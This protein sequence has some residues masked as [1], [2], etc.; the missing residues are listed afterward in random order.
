M[1]EVED[2][3]G[4]RTRFVVQGNRSMSWRANLWLAASLGAI[5]M[6]IAVALATFGLWLVIPF[7]GAEIVLI[8]TCLYLT[9]RRLSRKE[10]ITVE[11][12]AVRLEWGYTRPD[13]VV[14]LPRQ[15]T[16]AALSQPREPLPHGGPERRGPRP[17]LRARVL[18]EQGR[19]EDAARRPRRG[20]AAPRRRP[21]DARGPNI[22]LWSDDRMTSKSSAWR[23]MP[24]SAL[25][26]VLVA[27]LLA[28]LSG[29]AL[30]D[31]GALNMPDGVTPI[32]E[33]VKGL[34]MLIF[35]ICC[36][37]GVV[38]FGVMIVSMF[39][40][41]KSR[42]AKASDF[43][44]STTVEIVWT[45]VPLVILIAMAIPAARVLI[46]MEDFSDSEMSIKVT[47]YQWRWQYEYLDEGI[48]FYS[49]LDAEQNAARQQGSDIDL[50]Q[51]GETYLRDV[52]N[53]LVVP[54]GR[55]IRFLHTAAD[56]IHSWWVP[57]FAIKKDAIPG[58]INENW[59]TIE[60][61]GI[62]RGK[63]AELCG[64]DHG[65]MPIVVRAVPQEEFDAWVEEKKTELAAADADVMREHSTDELVAL[66]ETIHGRSCVGCHQKEGQGIPGMFPAIAGSEIAT[67]ALD[68]HLATVMDGV[69]G[70]PMAAFRDQ[71]SDTEIAAVVTYQ[72]N[73]FGNATGDA[74]QP[75]AVRAVREG[76]AVEPVRQSLLSIP[77]LNIDAKPATWGVN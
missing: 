22:E 19:E 72:R 64:R 9:L 41:R 67:G 52:D 36:A 55:K 37:I 71:L 54:V 5:C 69:E 76:E 10:V 11:G 12:E 68:A 56:V 65:F 73:A 28:G 2:S 77:E 58:F 18:P 49:A 70:S 45:V 8:T 1:I 40:H 75:R 13:R 38:V 14:D 4:G 35:Y 34:H 53:E 31:W 33:E 3:S 30:A 27:A 32:S 50:E 23:A 66:G 74:L 59:A 6:G 44:E 62:Y 48:A 17:Q 47:G 20:A 42:G 61:P 25:L 46:K 26:S 21:R 15:W 7:A 39:L 57:D 16:P 51:F 63:C 43:H 24:R 29:G 60:E